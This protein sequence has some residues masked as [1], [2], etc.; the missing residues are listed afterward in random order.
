MLEHPAFS[1]VTRAT[2]LLMA[3]EAQY[4]GTHLSFKNTWEF[5]AALLQIARI[6]KQTYKKA[7]KVKRCFSNLRQLS[8]QWSCF[9][10]KPST[11][12]LISFLSWKISPS[13]PNMTL[14]QL[15]HKT[16][17]WMSMNGAKITRMN[18]NWCKDT[19]NNVLRR[20]RQ[21]ERQ[22]QMAQLEQQAYQN[23]PAISFLPLVLNILA[24]FS[25]LSLFW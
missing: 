18:S 21:T 22:S 1:S 20:S 3:S 16:E 4:P 17:G 11:K 6:W 5:I 12:I 13:P 25:S 15:I 14:F 19:K 10:S 8:P 24:F 2:W 7:G 23:T 9:P